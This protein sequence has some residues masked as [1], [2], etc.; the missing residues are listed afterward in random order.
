[1]T[2]KTTAWHI[3]SAVSHLC[4]VLLV[5]I[6][7]VI[8]GAYRWI[9]NLFTPGDALSLPT[10]KVPRGD[11]VNDEECWLPGQVTSA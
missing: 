10:A 5:I 9:D 11:S 4:S 7:S 3:V 1:M 2:R 8:T 6:T